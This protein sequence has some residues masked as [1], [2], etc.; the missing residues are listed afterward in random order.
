MNTMR[1]PAVAACQA[2]TLEVAGSNPA[3][4]TNIFRGPRNLLCYGGRIA[5]S[6]RTSGDASR[7]GAMARQI[8]DGYAR[9]YGAIVI[10]RRKN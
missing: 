7:A 10:D 5:R 3:P 1:G 4:A 9:M 8:A 2:H 6:C